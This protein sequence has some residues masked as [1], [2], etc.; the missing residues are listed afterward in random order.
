M[1]REAIPC[2]TALRSHRNYGPGSGACCECSRIPATGGLLKADGPL[3]A[4]AP[5]NWG[6]TPVALEENSAVAW[7]ESTGFGQCAPS[8]LPYRVV[9]KTELG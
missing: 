8:F 6:N 1:R 9:V 7:L 2:V 4:I 3:N 5:Q